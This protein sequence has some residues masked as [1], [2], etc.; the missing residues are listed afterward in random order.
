MELLQFFARAFAAKFVPG[1]TEGSTEHHF[2]KTSKYNE[3]WVKIVALRKFQ[4][5][6]DFCDD[7]MVADAVMLA[8]SAE[9]TAVVP[10]TKAEFTEGEALARSPPRSSPEVPCPVLWSKF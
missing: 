2:T 10:I 1:L 5:T 8:H 9:V 7:V 6:M 4:V 3:T